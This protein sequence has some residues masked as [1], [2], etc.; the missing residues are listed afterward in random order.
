M[1]RLHN[2]DADDRI[3]VLCTGCS[4]SYRW[5]GLM[6]FHDIV[7]EDRGG[8][9]GLYQM[10]NRLAQQPLL[11]ADWLVVQLPTP[12]RSA[13]ASRT[14]LV[15]TAG[16]LGCFSWFVKRFHGIGEKAARKELLR[17]YIQEIESINAMHKRVLF[18]HYNVG[19]YPFRS[20]FDFGAKIAGQLHSDLCAA[21][22]HIVECDLGG[23]PG[24][25]IKEH[26]G[27]R[28]KGPIVIHRSGKP[29]ELDRRWHVVDPPGRWIEDVHPNHRADLLAAT[30]VEEYIR[31][32]NH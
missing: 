25:A 24:Y 11:A 17:R 23:L 1:K 3:R 10:R 7:W 9:L 30:A 29:I 28:G 21:G 26:E 22:L 8:G 18:F 2:A 27:D 20:P 15:N 4:W 14:P 5:P 16:T 12:I 32:H 6:H 31:G 13:E 19:G